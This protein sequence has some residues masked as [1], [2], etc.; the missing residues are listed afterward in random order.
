MD[1]VQLISQWRE[2]K[3]AKASSD[4]EILSISFIY[5]FIYSV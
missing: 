2:I 1:K 5:V 3:A 4:L